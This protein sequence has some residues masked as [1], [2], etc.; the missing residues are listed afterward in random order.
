MPSASACSLSASKRAFVSFGMLPVNLIGI[1]LLLSSAVFFLL[2]LKRPGLGLPTVGGLIT[3]VLGA[4][5]LFDPHVPNAHVSWGTIVPVALGTGLFFVFAVGAAVRARRLPPR[6]GRTPIIGTEGVVTTA[7]DPKGV[8]QVS[9]ERWTAKS[10]SG[11]V[12]AGTRVRVV[13]VE[14]LTLR[15]EPVVERVE[16]S[17]S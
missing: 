5:F 7:L 10:V 9:S 8:V 2:E 11:L 14:G 16:G 17:V 6:T 12:P 3:L 4:L 15:V 1:V 13:G